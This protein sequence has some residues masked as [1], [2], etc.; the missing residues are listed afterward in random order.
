M[1]R[2]DVDCF[3]SSRDTKCWWHDLKDVKFTSYIESDK[4]NVDLKTMLESY[5]TFRP[6][7]ISFKLEF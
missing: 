2:K 4:I 5:A 6:R 1:R 7:H 3:C